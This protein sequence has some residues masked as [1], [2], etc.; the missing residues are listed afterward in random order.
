MAKREEI[1]TVITWTAADDRATVYSMMKRVW[2]WCE[3]AGGE[4]IDTGCGT[5]DGVKVGR[6]FLV[7]VKLVRIRRPRKLSPEAS[8]KI[9]AAARERFAGKRKTTT[10]EKPAG[11]T[12]GSRFKRTTR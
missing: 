1:E 2:K 5:R 9:G 3:K 12:S 6:T 4:E 10:K 11:P 8:A 7:P